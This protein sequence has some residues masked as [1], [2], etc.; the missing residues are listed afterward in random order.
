MFEMNV[1][2][3]FSGLNSIAH[4]ENGAPSTAPA[5]NGIGI[6]LLTSNKEKKEKAGLKL[7]PQAQPVQG[8]DG[9]VLTTT[10]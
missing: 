10:L 5:P 1:S 9:V 4:G 8:K 2:V 7:T 6:S 3:C